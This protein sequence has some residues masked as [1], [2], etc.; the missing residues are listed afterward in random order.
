MEIPKFGKSQESFLEE[1]LVYELERTRNHRERTAIFV[2]H[3][4]NSLAQLS[5]TASRPFSVSLMFVF[6]SPVRHLRALLH[7]EL[8]KQNGSPG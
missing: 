2:H 5:P 6:S 7:L 8:K 1:G 4:L 3:H